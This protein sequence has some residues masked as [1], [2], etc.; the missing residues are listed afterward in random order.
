[1]KK[2]GHAR[3]RTKKSRQNFGK[4]RDFVTI[5]LKLF[6]FEENIFSGDYI[7]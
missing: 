4:N 3:A 2:A 5:G 1:M 6:D 7:R